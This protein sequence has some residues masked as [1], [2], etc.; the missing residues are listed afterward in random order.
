[1][2]IIL[3]LSALVGLFIL[4]VNIGATV[5]LSRDDTLESLQRW[6]QGI[7]LWVVPLI[8]GLTVLHLTA[9]HFPQAIPRW[10]AYWPLKKLV[11]GGVHTPNKNRDENEGPGVDLA[12]SHRQGPGG[13]HGSWD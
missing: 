1:M 7:F 5:A 9:S 13:D 4:W 2:E 3:I 8:G 12:I 11:K 6:A 10:V